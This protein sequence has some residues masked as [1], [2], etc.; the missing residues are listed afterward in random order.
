MTNKSTDFSDNA[1]GN[2][3]ASGSAGAMFDDSLRQKSKTSLGWTVTKALSDQV[4]SLIIF[5]MLARLLTKEEIGLFAMVYVFSEVGRII[6]TGGLVQ[7]IARAKK[8]R[9]ST[10]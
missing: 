5:I 8:G 10:D 7:L 3:G 9:R 2:T 6:A 4:F 1:S